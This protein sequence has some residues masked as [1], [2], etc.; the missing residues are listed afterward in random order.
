MELKTVRENYPGWPGLD[1]EV[2]SPEIPGEEGVDSFFG[3]VKRFLSTV[4]E[5]EPDAVVAAVTHGMVVRAI[6]H[7]VLKMPYGLESHWGGPFV[8]QNCAV[9]E[10]RTGRDGTPVLMRSN[11]TCHLED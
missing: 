7:A 8:P 3:R 10:I 1:A 9:T 11:D 2:E 5:S 4:A 6:C